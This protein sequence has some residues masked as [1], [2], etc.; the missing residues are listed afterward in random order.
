MTTISSKTKSR[1]KKPSDANRPDANEMA[2]KTWRCVLRMS[3]KSWSFPLPEELAEA[4]GITV[5][6]VHNWLQKLVDMGRIR[7]ISRYHY[8]IT[9]RS[10]K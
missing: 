6:S 5:N 8:R 1:S 2:E 9:G 4:M 10:I 7:K 3:E